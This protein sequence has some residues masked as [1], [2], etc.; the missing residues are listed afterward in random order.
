MLKGPGFNVHSF[1]NVL[2]LRVGK[3]LA[4]RQPMGYEMS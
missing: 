1:P 4:Q 3:T 2:N